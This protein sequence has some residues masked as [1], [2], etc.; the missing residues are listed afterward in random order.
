MSDH[1]SDLKPKFCEFIDKILDENVLLGKSVN[2]NS[3]FFAYNNLLDII[4]ATRAFLNQNQVIK[5]INIFL[6]YMMDPTTQINMKNNS[7]RLLLQLA[8]TL[9][10]QYQSLPADIKGI[11]PTH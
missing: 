5:A 10:R 11:G 6:R 3:K 1:L 8:D 9:N 7:S 2:E 4:Y